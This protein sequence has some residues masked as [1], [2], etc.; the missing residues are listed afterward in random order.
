MIYATHR[1]FPKD[2][3]ACDRM[4]VTLQAVTMIAAFSGSG[5]VKTLWMQFMLIFA[6]H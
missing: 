2:P 5:E 3:L 1:K 6:T 4:K